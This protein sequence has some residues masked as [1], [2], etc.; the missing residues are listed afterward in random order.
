MPTHVI[1]NP[2]SPPS[3]PPVRT[4]I[5]V[6]DDDEDFRET[7][8]MV[9]DIEGFRVSHVATTGEALDYLRATACSHI[10]LL[11]YA[12]WGGNAEMLLYAGEHDARLTRHRYAL[13][14]GRELAQFSDEAMS[15]ITARKRRRA[16]LA[17]DGT[18]R[19]A[20][21]AGMRRTLLPIVSRPVVIPGRVSGSSVIPLEPALS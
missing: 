15:L 11:D 17:R 5:L 3:A 21:L 7:L 13:M 18:C 4:P 1:H 20:R 8:V 16:G 19:W 12:L 6:V 10:V 14:T 9:L 2:L